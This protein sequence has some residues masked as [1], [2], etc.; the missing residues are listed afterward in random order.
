MPQAD[1]STRTVVKYIAVVIDLGSRGEL[2][3]IRRFI[4]SDDTEYN[5]LGSLFNLD[6]RLSTSGCALLVLLFNDTLNWRVY[7]GIEVVRRSV[8]RKDVKGP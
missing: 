2:K 1:V 8:C 3:V 4:N 5:P 6:L 7:V